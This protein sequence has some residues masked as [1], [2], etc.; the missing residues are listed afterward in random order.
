[1]IN[2]AGSLEASE[3]DRAELGGV[4]AR[5]DVLATLARVLSRMADEVRAREERLKQEVR[6]LWIEIDEARQTRKIAEITG[7]GL[8]RAIGVRRMKRRLALAALGAGS[9]SR[10]RRPGEGGR[11]LALLLSAWMRSSSLRRRGRPQRTN[12]GSAGRDRR[13]LTEGEV[14]RRLAGIGGALLPRTKQSSHRDATRGEMPAAPLISGR[15][16]RPRAHARSGRQ[17][18]VYADAQ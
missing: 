13:S 17:A 4:A 11:T 12:S 14:S 10:F 9:R 7:T 1:V 6:E 2:A 18:A 16:H 15:L 8:P 3:F 5:D